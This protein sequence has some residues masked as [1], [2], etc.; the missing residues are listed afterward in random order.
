MRDVLPTPTGSSSTRLPPDQTGRRVL[1]RSVAALMALSGTARATGVTASPVGA[2]PPEPFP[3]TVGLLVPGPQ[4]GR[5]ERWAG[6]IGPALRDAMPPGTRLRHLS[7]GGADG[8]TAANQFTARVTPDGGTALLVPGETVLAWLAGDPRARFDAAGWLPVLA[9]LTSGVLC[10]RIP[11]TALHP[12]ISL[13]VA[14]ASQ[15]GPELAALLGLDL[16]GIEPLPVRGVHD[17][18]A[19]RQALATQAADAVLLSGP[20][21]REQLADAAALGAAPLFTLGM[22]TAG[23][24]ARDPLLPGLPI[25][26]ELIG[27]LRG[28]PPTAGLV[29][30]WRAAAAAAVTEFALVLPPLTP[31]TLVAMWRHAGTEAA[32]DLQTQTRGL[33]LL[34]GAEASAATT[35]MA[36][37]AARMLE[38]RRWLAMRL[39]WRPA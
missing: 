9:G 13:R 39:N 38:L 17:A 14:C 20:M 30:A 11:A 33:R 34:A 18:A 37:D 4:D 10:S 2:P 5:M 27:R 22:P 15:T 36:C 12:G 7:R 6:L 19:A 31:A 21:T 29:A 26:P 28:P 25:A 35:T 1:L 23:G 16:M 32:P 3:E 8:V 24:T